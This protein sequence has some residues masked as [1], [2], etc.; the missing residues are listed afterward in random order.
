MQQM[1]GDLPVH[2]VTPIRP[3]QTYGVDFAGPFVMRAIPAKTKTTFKAYMSIS[4]C[5]STR[6]VHLEVV[7]A[8]N[9]E[10]FL[11]AF[12]RFVS[13]CGRPSVVFSDNGTNFVGAPKEL[14]ELA[15]LVQSQQHNTT[16]AD[17][18]SAS[19]IQWKFHPP[20]APH[21]GGLW[22]LG[23]KSA[24]Y[25]LHRMSGETR[26]TFEEFTTLMAQIESCLNSRPITAMSSDPS[27]L[28][29]LTPGHFLIG[30]PLNAVPDPCLA[31]VNI[32]RLDRWQQIQRLQQQFWSRCS[33]EF[34][35]RLQQRPKWMKTR[36]QP[37]INDL[38]LLKDERLPP[39]KI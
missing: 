36:D 37:Q 5:L 32:N 28:A 38:V 30:G 34:L 10:T 3:F 19:G 35:T 16:V 21:F 2:R 33:G 24:K 17:D 13:R 31:E 9:S 20:G 11:A 14:S 12:R 29:A 6:A 15:S 4:V 23:V 25:H 8:L 39:Q 1:M 22:E 26:L 27:D 18:L 7:S